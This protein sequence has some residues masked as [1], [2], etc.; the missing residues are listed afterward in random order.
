MG[1]WD[2][3]CLLCGCPCHSNVDNNLKIKKIISW[4]D[5]CTILTKN[6]KII[7]K[8]KETTCS[9]DF[10][11]PNNDVYVTSLDN[12]D[13]IF[14]YPHVKN[15]GLF[16][17]DD[18]WKYIKIKYKIEL[19]YSDLAIIKNKNNTLPYVKYNDIQKYWD[20]FF[21]YESLINDDNLWMCISPLISIKNAS[22]I[23]K[24][25]KQLK[26]K[27]DRKGPT[28]S[29]SFYKSGDIKYGNNDK[30]WINNKGKW[31]EMKG[32]IKSEQVEFNKSLINKTPQIGEYNTKPIFIK[33]FT[34]KKKKPFA[35]VISLI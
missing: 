28:L 23:N 32:D 6:N 1:C 33:E 25:I 17:H 4:F 16:I 2:I 9:V 27:K 34:V 26:I 20:Q 11:A 18:C 31:S 12:N 19:K 10:K 13:L 3:Y 14:D 21:D 24:I 7:H 22:R 30:F 35:T 8:C 29:A 15:I 5:K